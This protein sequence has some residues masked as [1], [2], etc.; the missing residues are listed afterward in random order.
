VERNSHISVARIATASWIAIALAGAAMHA[1]PGRSTVVIEESRPFTA[2]DFEQAGPRGFGD[3]NNSWAQS[4]VWWRNHLYVGT[5]RESVCTSLFAIWQFASILISPAFANTFLPY[6]PLDA[7]LS[8][9]PDGADLP[10]Q[11]EIWRWSPDSE[12]WQRVFQSPL[13]LDNPGTGAPAPPR[14][15]K[16]LPYEIAIRGLRVHTEPDGTEALYAFGVNSTVMWDR[17][18]LPP[19]RI[20]RSVDGV[21]FT[22]IPQTPGT[23]LWDLPFNPDH[24]SF[25]SPVSHAGKLFVLSGPI[26]GQGSLIGS[27][28]P[29]LGNNAWFLASPPGLLFFELG[30]FNGWLYL[31]GF[32]SING[33]SVLKTRA[34]GAPPYTFI[35]VVP[36]GAFLPIRPSK[37]VVSMHE[38]A[39]RLYMG[40]ATQTEVIRINPDDTW[41]LV[42]GP[43]RQVPLPG[44]GTAWKYPLSGLDAGFGH[45]LNDHAWQMDDPLRHLY[46]GTYNAAVGSK[47]DPVHAPL[48]QHNSGAHLYRTPDGWYYSA[49]T[50]NGFANP[51]DPFGGPLD[52]G[53]R[54]MA[55]TPYGFFLGTANDFYGLAIFRAASRGSMAPLPPYRVEIDKTTEGSALLSWQVTRVAKQYQIWRAEVLP[56]FVRDDLSFEGF[57]GQMGN[58]IPDTYVGPYQRVGTTQ[59]VYFLDSTVEL[60]KKYMYYVLWEGLG[61]ELSDQSNLV[62]FPLLAPPMTFAQLL[63]ALDV[64]AQ[65]QRLRPPLP[66]LADLRP[67]IV[68]AQQLAASCQLTDAINLLTSIKVG[69]Y[70]L[71]PEATDFG[72]LIG[73][74]VRR[75]AS[76]KQFP[77][78]VLST[79]FCT[80]PAGR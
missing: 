52:Y 31:G 14:I 16:K 46:I 27:A 10:L 30:V 4:M 77:Q 42:V 59:N 47:M 23:F 66:R 5:A 56:I 29:A 28:H 26:F 17:S 44:G 35:T 51:S 19:P 22:P 45:T 50:T 18:Q 57:I 21:T 25:R 36:P 60:A 34:E 62:G 15:G 70:I 38:Y 1:Q 80:T 75:L 13:E 48:L 20:L 73:K 58:K 11:A 37:S 68:N 55:S 65:R 72:I 43:P 2:Q 78:A 12:S 40:T 9:I 69:D 39:G 6:P 32:D 8:C 49:V 24:S 74:L 41:D 64:L 63:Q 7:E 53:V 61:G 76:Y 79:E 67:S 3:I 54:A 71:E 33:Y